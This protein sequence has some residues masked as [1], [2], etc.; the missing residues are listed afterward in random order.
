MFLKMSSASARVFFILYVGLD[1]FL[2]EESI[3]KL[4]KHSFID[5]FK[6]KQLADFYNDTYSYRLKISTAEGTKYLLYRNKDK[7]YYSFSD[8]EYY[9]GEFRSLDTYDDDLP[10]VIVKL[11]LDVANNNIS[12]DDGYDELLALLELKKPENFYYHFVLGAGINYGYGLPDWKALE[13][14]F[15]LSVDSKLN[16]GSCRSISDNVFNNSYGSFQILKD[17]DKMEY[18]KKLMN[19]VKSTRVPFKSDNTTLTAISAVLYAQSEIINQQSVLTFNYDGLLEL[20][21]D[22]CYKISS[23]TIYKFDNLFFFNG[24][25]IVVIHSHGFLDDPPSKKQLDSIVLTTEEYFDNYNTPSSYGYSNLFNHL[26]ITCSFVGNS[27]TDYEEQKVINAHFNKFPA[28][29]HYCFCS[30]KDVPLETMMYKTIFLIKIGVIPLWYKSH[31]DYKEE[32]Y[33]YAE[34]LTSDVLLE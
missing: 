18:E 21:L 7:K 16:P 9:S 29:F 11:L 2:K 23:K 27:I 12:R 19:M 6:E 24:E 3:E 33:R 20:A 26:N 28:Q 4:T 1:C 25:K 31:D 13:K 34:R 17:I 32:F 30:S 22:S 14:D 15:S 8:S 5:T 10:N